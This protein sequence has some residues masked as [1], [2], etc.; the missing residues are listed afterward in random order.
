MFI[1]L[2]GLG[3]VSVGKVTQGTFKIGMKYNLDGNL[4]TVKTIIY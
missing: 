3:V 2:Q 1:L 4:L